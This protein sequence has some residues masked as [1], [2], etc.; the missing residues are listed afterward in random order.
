MVSDV[1]QVLHAGA[2]SSAT[3]LVHVRK[4]GHGQSVKTGQVHLYSA[5]AADL[6]RIEI[7]FT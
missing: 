6:M 2:T 7:A 1:Y 3:D 4:P 5:V